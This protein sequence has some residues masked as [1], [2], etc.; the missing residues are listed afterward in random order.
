MKSARIRFSAEQ[1]PLA[2]I[3][4]HTATRRKDITAD[5]VRSG[6]CANSTVLCHTT[7]DVLWHFDNVFILL[8]ED[9]LNCTWVQCFC[10]SN[11]Q[12]IS[13]QFLG[14]CQDLASSWATQSAHVCNVCSFWS[15]RTTFVGRTADNTVDA[16]CTRCILLS[17]METVEVVGY[18]TTRFLGVLQPKRLQMVLDQGKCTSC[19]KFDKFTCKRAALRTSASPSNRQWCV[20]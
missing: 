16:P 9:K 15:D 8:L 14:D 11:D 4:F 5:N 18:D 19:F 3:A 6:R 12:H 20:H 7:I 2:E 13:C 1:S 10:L 17:P